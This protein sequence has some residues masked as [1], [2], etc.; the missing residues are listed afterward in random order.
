MYTFAVHEMIMTI[1][2]KP[3]PIEGI[4]S[5]WEWNL[6]CVFVRDYAVTSNSRI[7]LVAVNYN[8]IEIR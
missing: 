5:H 1:F 4:R 6:L 3:A 7:Y 2:I 8:E